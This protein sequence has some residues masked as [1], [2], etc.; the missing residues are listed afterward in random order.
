MR[1]IVAKFQCK[2]ENENKELLFLI[3][4]YFKAKA[5]D[6]RNA[7]ED[8]RRRMNEIYPTNLRQ[9]E[10]HEMY[11]SIKA[12]KKETESRKAWLFWIFL[13]ETEKQ[14]FRASN[15]TLKPPLADGKGS[16]QI[17]KIR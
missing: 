13:G 12:K 10:K 9:I 3:V 14:T 7:W 15:E 11:I 4:R 6:E 16:I 1:R 2:E 5:K 8:E 17:R